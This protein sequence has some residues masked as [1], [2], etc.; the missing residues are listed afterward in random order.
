[1][2]IN[3]FVGTAADEQTQLRALI[4]IIINN[5]NIIPIGC[6]DSGYWLESANLEFTVNGQIRI[7]IYIGFLDEFGFG[8]EF[9]Y[10]KF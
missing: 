9:L 3:H 6:V 4:T 10:E 8:F 2:A 7:R 5:N 1:M